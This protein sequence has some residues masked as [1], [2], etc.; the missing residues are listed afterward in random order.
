MLR[1]FALLL[2][3]NIHLVINGQINF[4]VK[5]TL[6]VNDSVTVTNL[7]GD[8]S[9]YY[10]HFCSANLSYA[11]QEGPGL[12]NSGNLNG[13]AFI[14]LVKDENENYYSFITNHTDG[15]IT[16][17]YIGKNLLSTPTATNLGNISGIIPLHTEGIQ[18]KFSNGNWYGF[19]VG[20]LA[21]ESRLVRLDFGNSLS[22]TPIA[23]N[24]GN[25]GNLAIQLICIYSKK[26][27]NGQVLR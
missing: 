18:I 17:L 21:G 8:A 10:W 12:G 7:S 13:P 11:P 23:V 1:T 27:E 5:D 2:I 24:L 19:I 14:G 6:C 20:G 9:T 16:R 26:V 15:S 3:I 25:I 4:L 22:N